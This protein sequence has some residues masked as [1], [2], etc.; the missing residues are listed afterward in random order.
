LLQQQQQYLF[1][2]LVAIVLNFHQIPKTK[3]FGARNFQRGRQKYS[4]KK[5]KRDLCKKLRNSPQMTAD[6]QRV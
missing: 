3:I 1:A 6:G 4:L 5:L 2:T